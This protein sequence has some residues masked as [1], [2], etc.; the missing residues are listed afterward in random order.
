MIKQKQSKQQA[1]QTK[2]QQL[3]RGIL[4]GKGLS[5]DKGSESETQECMKNPWDTLLI[6][7]LNRAHLKKKKEFKQRY[8][9]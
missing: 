8:V 7:K 4:G 1:N 3:Q 2:Q 5:G 6:Y 9:A